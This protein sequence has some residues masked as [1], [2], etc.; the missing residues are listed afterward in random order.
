MRPVAVGVLDL[1]LDFGWVVIASSSGWL[2]FAIVDNLDLCLVEGFVMVVIE[3]SSSAASS[4]D[5]PTHLL[6]F[7]LRGL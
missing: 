5:S 1:A 2:S 4:V 6:I 3:A 7:T